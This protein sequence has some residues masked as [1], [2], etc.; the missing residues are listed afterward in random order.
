M[1]TIPNQ[2]ASDRS[3]PS[4]ADAPVRDRQQLKRLFESLPPH[5]LEAEM[6]LLGSMLIEPQVVGETTTANRSGGA[7]AESA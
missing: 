3:K 1:S 7:G 5:A 4:R 6:S 2:P